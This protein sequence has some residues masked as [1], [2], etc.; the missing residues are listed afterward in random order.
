MDSLDLPALIPLTLGFMVVHN[1]FDFIAKLIR[2]QP[3]A[4]PA[5]KSL[6]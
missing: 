4:K 5:R 3:R 6:A 2:R 1:L